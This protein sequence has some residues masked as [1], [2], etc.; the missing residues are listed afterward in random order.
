[1]PNN[2]REKLKTPYGRLFKNIE[3]LRKFRD[4][5]KAKFKDKFIV[6]VGDVV[7]N[8]MLS[9]GWDV[10]LCI[11]DNKTLRRDYKDYK[12]SENNKKNLENFLEY[13]KGKEFTVWNPAGMLTEEAFRIVKDAL[14]FK[15]SKIFVDGEEDL[16]VI[17]C[18]K[19]C[20]PNTILFYGQPNEGIVMVEINSAVQRHIED[21]FSKFYTGICEE[22]NAYGHENILSKHKNTFE[23][24]KD[25]YLTKRGD[26]IIGVN[27]DK[28]AYD[29]SEKFKYMLKGAN[30]NV[31]IFI[32]CNQF[33]DEVKAKGNENLI[34]TNKD[35]IVVR[36]SKFIDDR[37]VAVM[38]DKAAID[39]NREMIKILSEEKEKVKI[40]LKFVVWNEN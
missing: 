2:I 34:L 1:M 31:R 28:G 9:D 19:F 30:S 7:S 14:N 29:F 17:P 37:T 26:C 4:K 27:A 12:G 15:H 13:F 20:Q 33:R 35:D 16:F 10:N 40:T 38:A 5:F 11:Y 36:K 8:S 23:V 3:E 32:I 21:L 39:L 24:T 25:N 18:V 22:V 6:C